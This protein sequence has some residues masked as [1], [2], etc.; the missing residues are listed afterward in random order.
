MKT[1]S[2]TQHGDGCPPPWSARPILPHLRGPPS[3]F[4]VNA[5]WRYLSLF[6]LSFFCLCALFTCIFCLYNIITGIISLYKK[7]F[8]LF[9]TTFLHWMNLGTYHVNQTVES[10]YRSAKHYFF[11]AGPPAHYQ[12]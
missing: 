1:S 10:C 6:Y 8:A 9:Q 5:R 3:L 12:P 11:R 2:S 7:L 4:H